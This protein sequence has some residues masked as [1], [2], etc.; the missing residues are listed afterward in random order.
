MA[1]NGFFVL[2]KLRGMFIMGDVL[3]R[4]GGVMVVTSPFGVP[5]SMEDEKPMFFK[6]NI[7][8]LYNFN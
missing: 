8:F 3:M 7:S 2:E 4:K 1:A 5:L 6:E